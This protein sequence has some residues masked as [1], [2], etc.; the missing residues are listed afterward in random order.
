M[1]HAAATQVAETVLADDRAFNP[2][3]SAF[4]CR[5]RQNAPAARHRLGSKA[6]SNAQV[7]YLTAERFR[8][9]FVEAIKSQDALAFMTNSARSDILLIDDLEFMRGEDRAGVRTYR[10][11]RC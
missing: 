1:A 8:Y 7:L 9:Q 10:R 4:Q 6:A 3:L 2:L 5:A 11:I